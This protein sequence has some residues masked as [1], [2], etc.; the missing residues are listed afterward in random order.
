MWSIFFYILRAKVEEPVAF[1]DERHGIE[2]LSKY[3]SVKDLIED[4][5]KQNKTCNL[6][7]SP[8]VNQLHYYLC[9]KIAYINTAKLYKS[10]VSLQFNIQTWHLRL[11]H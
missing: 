7:S 2:H 6:V 11:S 3:I 8:L 5:K 4:V 9:T 1:D 10:K